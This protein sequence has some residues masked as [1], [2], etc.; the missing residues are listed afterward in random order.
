ME[1]IEN[2]HSSMEPDAV[3][4]R[5][6]LA[7]AS[8][9]IEGIEWTEKEKTYLDSIPLGISKKELKEYILNFVK[10]GI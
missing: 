10:K 2:I 1:N 4:Y 7:R 6:E 9:A 3:K 5:V 8:N